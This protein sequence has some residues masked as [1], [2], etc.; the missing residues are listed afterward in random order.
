MSDRC[1]LGYLFKYSFDILF[2]S[3]S[4]ALSKGPSKGKAKTS[5]DADPTLTLTQMVKK[6]MGDEDGDKVSCIARKSIFRVL[7]QV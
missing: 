4:K 1:P 7:D 3:K 2:Q 6:A 5:K